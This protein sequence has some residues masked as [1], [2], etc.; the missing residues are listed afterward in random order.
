MIEFS[1]RKCQGFGIE[2]KEE[3]EEVHE[4]ASEDKREAPVSGRETG[5]MKGIDGDAE[6]DEIVDHVHEDVEEEVPVAGQVAYLIEGKNLRENCRKTCGADEFDHVDGDCENSD[7]KDHRGPR[8]N[9]HDRFHALDRVLATSEVCDVAR[10]GIFAECFVE[11]KTTTAYGDESDNLLHPDVV[12][13]EEE[14]IEPRSNEEVVDD[15]THKEECPPDAPDLAH[16]MGIDEEGEECDKHPHGAGIEAIEEAKKDTK[17][18]EGEVEE[19]HRSDKPEIEEILRL[20][21]LT[22]PCAGS[23]GSARHRNT[24]TC[25]EECFKRKTPLPGPP[26]FFV[27][28]CQNLPCRFVCVITLEDLSI[29]DDRWHALLEEWRHFLHSLEKFLSSK[30]CHFVVLD[31]PSLFFGKFLKLRAVRASVTY[32]DDNV[33]SVC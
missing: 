2:D 24:P 6:D 5:G 8:R 32:K 4:E 7:S 13:D 33:P 18:G 16:V 12:T 14:G 29:Q 22:L 28:T 23:F 27:A 19:I 15:A 31:S 20:I 21:C 26:T 1:L 17:R 11:V 3:A 9:L 10:I 30:I 25:F